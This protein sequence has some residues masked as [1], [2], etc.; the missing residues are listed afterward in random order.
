MKK[1]FLILT[2]MVSMLFFASCT[3]EVID[4]LLSKKPDIAFL[5]QEGSIYQN[6]NFDLGT[7]LKFS[8][9]V[10]PNSESESA[11]RT[12]TFAITN[13]QGENVFEDSKDCTEQQGDTLVFVETF[14]PTEAGTYTVTATITDAANNQNIAALVVTGIQP[15]SPDDIIGEFAGNVMIKCDV[16]SNNGELNGQEFNTGDLAASFLLTCNDQNEASARFTI[17]GVEYAITGTRNGDTFNFD[18]FQ[19]TTT[20]TFIAPITL[21]LN[22]V[23][24]AILDGDELTIDGDVNGTG[25]ALFN[26]IQAELTGTI[27][28]VLNRVEE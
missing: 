17:D 12:F 27:Q 22:I 20:Y 18:E 4:E 28:G 2:C 10:N 11:L 13:Q 16:A 26:Q 19:Y 9:Q 6:A 25:S 23:M 5:N 7:P 8:V 1:A 3:P 24:N 14:T 21:N 15:A